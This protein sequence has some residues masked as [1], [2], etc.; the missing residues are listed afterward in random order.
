M[1]VTDPL[2][3]GKDFFARSS[4]I[5]A[6]W[7]VPGD[8][9]EDSTTYL[10]LDVQYLNWWIDLSAQQSVF[11]EPARMKKIAERMLHY[12]TPLGPL[13]LF[14]DSDG[15]ASSA[16][17]YIAAF[18]R[19]GVAYQD[20]AFSWAARRMFEYVE[21]RE[22]DT[23]ASV[24]D[25]Q[26]RQRIMEGTMEAAILQHG[27]LAVAKPPQSSSA[28]T[29]RGRLNWSDYVV[30]EQTPE[31]RRVVDSGQVPDKLVLRSGAAV[32]DSH[33]VFN[34]AARAGH[35]HAEAGALVSF[36]AGESLLLSGTPYATS[37][38][39]HQNIFQVS[40]PEALDEFYAR[41]TGA[42]SPPVTPSPT[43]GVLVVEFRAK[44]LSG[45]RTLAVRRASGNVA[46]PKISVELNQD[47]WS[48]HAVQLDI[49]SWAGPHPL[50]FSLV[51]GHGSNVVARGSFLIDDVRV[52]AMGNQLSSWSFD[53]GLDGFSPV[54][55]THPIAVHHRNAAYC[56]QPP[57]GGCLQIDVETDVYQRAETRSVDVGRFAS[58]GDFA[59]AEI[60]LRS[61]LGRPVDVNRF[62][63]FLGGLGIWVRDVA[64][65]TEDFPGT[66][67]PTWNFGFLKQSGISASGDWYVGG[68]VSVPI[69]ALSRNGCTSS[70][71]D[72]LVQWYNR[73]KDLLAYVAGS[74][75]SSTVPVSSWLDD[76]GQ[77]QPNNVA[78]QVVRQVDGLASGQSVYFDSLLLP[79]PPTSQ[80][81]EVAGRVSWLVENEDLGVLSVDAVG[82]QGDNMVVVG[83]NP[84]NQ[85]VSLPAVGVYT[86]ASFFRFVL[87]G[88]NLV[89]YDGVQ[90]TVL[91][92]GGYD[93]ADGGAAADYHSRAGITLTQNHALENDIIGWD[94]V[95]ESA[96]VSGMASFETQDTSGDSQGAVRF[97][98]FSGGV[99]HSH[100]TGLRAQTALID[101][102]QRVEVV[103]DA[104]SLGGAGGRVNIQRAWGGSG[105]SS[106]AVQNEWRR[107]RGAF[108]VWFDTSELVFSNTSG[109]GSGLIIPTVDGEFL[110]DNVVVRPLA[111]LVLNPHVELDISGWSVH[112][113]A[114]ADH[115]T[116]DGA[117]GSSSSVLGGLA[118]PGPGQW[119]RHQHGV[120]FHTET[121]SA[122]SHVEVGFW[123]KH[124]SGSTVLNL[125]R[126]ASLL[127]GRAVALS[128]TWKPH[129]VAFA[130]AQDTTSFLLN[131]CADN[132]C[133][134][135][136]VSQ[137]EFLVDNMILSKRL[138]RVPN[139]F[140]D[141]DI[142]GWV[143]GFNGVED[144]GM[145]RWEA[146][147]AMSIEVGSGVN[148]DPDGTA[149]CTSLTDAEVDYGASHL[150]SFTAQSL[151][152]VQYLR[153]LTESDAAV[154][155]T[156]GFG[157]EFVV[158]LTGETGSLCFTTVLGD[159]GAAA[160][161]VV[162]GHFRLDSVVLSSGR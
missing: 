150:V 32:S 106:F 66:V 130:V 126:P 157:D 140:F 143:S 13:A 16:G 113:N 119:Y 71:D 93:L 91:E 57:F 3:D 21:R 50:K 14:G 83:V 90:A 58:H 27:D 9:D 156:S 74:G 152:G 82:G 39:L 36:S 138:N 95:L 22:S 135:Q 87:D 79:H 142:E 92:W 40:P 145:A 75:V 5:W 60:Q 99:R 112:G 122:H 33:A 19:W 20:P 85:V 42:E 153:V 1:G 137:G 127:E 73:P 115:E 123:A 29:Y 117:L 69:T 132:P 38:P 159:Q 103:V 94:G 154:V 4:E 107:Y 144:D 10:S 17:R 146:G 88:G 51:R 37:G 162:P 53:S 89:Q 23:L 55:P 72:Y 147:A 84:S 18:E 8:I 111:N 15:F 125:Q 109:V 110:L 65:A 46:G 52:S 28:V 41:F 118:P 26:Y 67:G 98:D 34:L 49:S 116:A 54:N 120:E 11:S 133:S 105:R 24:L 59:S 96:A 2:R 158:D 78:Y 149:V 141:A 121:V 25:Q 56:N 64:E 35:S 108:D 97:S 139:G 62:V 68:K 77:L 70:C 48:T 134:D 161:V 101:G 86:D 148:P 124:V 155:E 102:N 160:E 129:R 6:L 30:S 45:A 114:T 80:P 31:P 131:S 100:R 151:S 128:A 76:A 47:V 7:H 81:E 136:G 43:T 63:V 61:H 12:A 44:S 104:K